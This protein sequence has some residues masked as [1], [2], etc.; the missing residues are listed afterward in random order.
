MNYQDLQEAKASYRLKATQEQRKPFHKIREEFISYFTPLKIKTMKIEE[1]VIGRGSKTNNFCYG[2]ERS[3]DPLGRILGAT[4]MKFGVYYSEKEGRYI[5]AKKYGSNYKEAFTKVKNCILDLL[6]AGKN[7]DYDRIISN[8]LSTMLKGKILSTYY[9]DL[10]L[11]I[12][13]EEHLNHYLVALDL[14]TE[15][16]MAKDPIYKRKALIDFKNKDK[17]MKKW[18]LDIFSHFLCFEY[19]RAPKDETTPSDQDDVDYEFPSADSY[20]YVNMEISIGG[21]SKTKAD[22]TRNTSSPNY[23]KEA[24]KCK[25]L[26]DRGEKIV[27]KAEM[28]RVMKELQLSDKLAA[29]KVIWKSRES[30]SYGFDILSVNPDGSPRYIE[31]KATQNKVGDM[32]FYYTLNELE[33][34]KQYGK[35]YYIYI[36]YDILS[37]RPKIWRIR[38][39]FLKKELIIKPIQFKVEVKIK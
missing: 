34:A 5:F 4:S 29:K 6:N 11:N 19:P 39:P 16:L 36:V 27:M 24:K 20:E 31:V 15:K 38:N 37:K 23:E 22:Y 9:P 30:D 25:K 18:S 28:D 10:Y 21:S 32:N 1:Y 17:D 26:G 7:E 13:S 12:F 35:Q 33:T 3:L 8:P 14:D 2:I